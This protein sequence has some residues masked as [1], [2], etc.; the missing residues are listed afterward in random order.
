MVTSG[1]RG[2]AALAA[3]LILSGAALIGFAG[4]VAAAGSDAPSSNSAR[5]VPRA[6]DARMVVARIPA[7]ASFAPD[8]G[9]TTIQ[10]VTSR[11][12]LAK[13]DGKAVRVKINGTWVKVPY[14]Y[15]PV[16]NALRYD[17]KLRIGLGGVDPLGAPMPTYVASGG[18]TQKPTVVAPVKTATTGT[19]DS[20]ASAEAALGGGWQDSLL[21]SVNSLR[22]GEGKAPLVLCGTLSNAAQG[23]ANF[24]ASNGYFGHNYQDETPADRIAFAGYSSAPPAWGE[25]IAAGDMSVSATMKTWIDSPGHHENMVNPAYTHLG[26]GLSRAAD[27]RMYWV[28]TF[29]GGGS[30]TK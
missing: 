16:W 12:V 20:S 7:K 13:S 28:Q 17:E 3:A 15:V 25:N 21:S 2:T 4:P 26:L 6:F 24:M 14:Y 9:V 1:I 8:T 30:C 11:R 23:W 5:P 27:G 22:A 19:Y 10:Q 18:P 29:G